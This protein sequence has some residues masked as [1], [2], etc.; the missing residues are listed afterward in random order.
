ME[1]IIDKHLI[2]DIRDI[3]ISYADEYKH[4]YEFVIWEM[5]LRFYQG[6][7][8][9]NGSYLPLAKLCLPVNF[10]PPPQWTLPNHD[11]LCRQILIY[12]CKKNRIQYYSVGKQK[13]TIKMY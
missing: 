11:R 5:G 2:P 6:K 10:G 7:I 9:V 4:Q 13:S 3:V 8:N 12:Y 1:K